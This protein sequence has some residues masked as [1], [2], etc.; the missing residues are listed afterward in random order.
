LKI[1]VLGGTG[2]IGLHLVKAL[3]V[4]HEVHV[5]S[6]DILKD[7][8]QQSG[9]VYY[10]G[11]FND[12]NV[13]IKALLGIEIVYH[14]I[15]ATNPSS[16]SDNPIDDVTKNLI[17]TINFLELLKQNHIKKLIYVS[18]GGTVYGNPIQLPVK[19]DHSLNP[20]DSYGITKLAIEHTIKRY[21]AEL[22]F[23]YT[24]IRPSNPFG[25]G[26]CIGK[27]QGVITHFFNNYINNH[28]VEIW[29]SGEEQRD[30]IYISDLVDLLCLVITERADNKIYNVGSGQGT[31]TLELLES[32]N[33]ITEK[34]LPIIFKPK[35]IY[36]VKKIFLDISKAN[37]ELKWKPKY[38]LNEGLSI[39]F[40]WL[41]ESN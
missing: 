1:L 19:E 17:G 34:K 10:N 33:R 15:S 8:L 40:K 2:F 7:S 32:I 24:I 18:S 26:Q 29:G 5:F 9:V 39:Y 30:Y 41:I 35:P 22:S 25:P 12:R 13:L 21:A 6:K 27:S 16:A 38:S 23:S 3:S 20:L 14:L 11:D 28:P 37:N 4:D 36:S 31:T